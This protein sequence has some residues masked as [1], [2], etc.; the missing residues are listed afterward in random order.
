MCRQDDRQ[1]QHQMSVVQSPTALFFSQNRGSAPRFPGFS[2]G[3]K[4]AA[5]IFSLKYSQKYYKR[6]KPFPALRTVKSSLRHHK[7][8][9]GYK[10][11]RQSPTKSSFHLMKRPF[12]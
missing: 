3:R 6:P 1:T 8:N 12:H 9:V 2:D 11:C 5:L 4:G 7:S 10:K